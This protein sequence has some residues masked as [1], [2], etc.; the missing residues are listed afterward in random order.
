MVDGADA[1]RRV[2]V[3]SACPRVRARQPLVMVVYRLVV[4]GVSGAPESPKVRATRQDIR[5][6][7]EAEL[8]DQSTRHVARLGN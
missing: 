2:R 4:A 7:S 6:Q 3:L 1:P 8:H 5:A